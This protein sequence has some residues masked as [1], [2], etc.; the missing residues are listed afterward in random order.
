M[1]LIEYLQAHPSIALATTFVFG[2]L[3]G[4]F[5]NVVIYRLPVMMERE[6]REQC[7]EFAAQGTPSSNEAEPAPADPSPAFN[8]V[9]P[10]S[11]CPNCKAAIAAHQNIPI[12]SYALQRGKCRA[13]DWRIPLRYPA[14]ELLTALMSVVVIAHFGVSV[15]GVCGLGFTY[16]L[17][18]AA[19]IDLDTMYLPDNITLPLLWAGL[20][21][22]L[23]DTFV[24]L[25]TAVIGAIAGYLSLWS[26]YWAFK[27][28]TGKEGMG[29]GDFKLLAALGAWL[30][31]SVLPG[32]ILLSSL[33][34]A[35]IG[36]T[37]IVV[38]GHERQIPIPFGPYI[39]AAG[40]LCLIWGDAVSA[41]YLDGLFL[42]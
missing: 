6:W 29:Y 30:G 37:L 11:R 36:V 3:V 5:L 13:C 9:V 42:H 31:W 24:A 26:I 19:F 21:A 15:A 28:F 25:E 12:I 18:T 32:A 2:L 1:L 14:V 33:V 22:N 20:A 10:R 35:V 8:L 23:A 17:I 38:R 16:A 4:S 40:W 39:A 27:L 34:G 7:H 41:L